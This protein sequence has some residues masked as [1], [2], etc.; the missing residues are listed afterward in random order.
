MCYKV[1]KIIDSFAAEVEEEES[2]AIDLWTT[3]SSRRHCVLPGLANYVWRSA[4]RLLIDM[5]RIG[6]GIEPVIGGDGVSFRFNLRPVD[7]INN[8]SYSSSSSSP[9]LSQTISLILNV[10]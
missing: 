9:A 8:R 3:T 2:L 1:L 6:T 7:R 5:P 10:V 4:G